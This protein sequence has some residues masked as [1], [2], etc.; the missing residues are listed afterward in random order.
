MRV[1]ETIV[2]AALERAHDRPLS[3]AVEATSATA[4]A[5]LDELVADAT[6]RFAAGSPDASVLVERGAAQ[7]CVSP[8]DRKVVVTAYQTVTFSAV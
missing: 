4:L 3:E 5:R 7:L 2:A 1:T 6:T 8:G